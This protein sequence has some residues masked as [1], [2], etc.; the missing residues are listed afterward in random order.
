MFNRDAA[1]SMQFS[2]PD[3]PEQ[4]QCITHALNIG[5]QF[6]ILTKTAIFRMLTAE[7]VDPERK[8]P[9]TRHSYEKLYSIGTQT[10]MIART[11][12]QFEEILGLAIQE[13]EQKEKLLLQ[14][15]ECTKILLACEKSL[16]HIYSNTMD[17]M[18]KCDQV[19]ETH[20][21][22]A[23]IPALPKIPD[24][25]THVSEFLLNGKLLLINSFNF[26]HD[27]F[28]MPFNGKN[29][30]HFDKHQQ[31]IEKQFGKVHPIH[32]MIS[33]DINWI[34]LISE[35]SNAIR[36]PEKGQTIEVENITLKPGNQFSIPAWRYDL[37]KKGLGRQDDFTDLLHN[38]GIFEHNMVT[39]FEELLIL[40]IQEKIKD[41][42]IFSL[43]K[44]KAE[45]V[46]QDC[47][48]LYEINLK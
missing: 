34:R 9:D 7:T 23:N 15:W 29:A 36:H 38:F 37:T 44:K 17:L 2:D 13:R 22:K 4:E 25:D 48:V 46:Q 24:L 5:G 39:F 11:I 12:I 28:G 21:N 16:Y 14:V 20:K 18:P 42:P 1:I 40:C 8:H 19:I 10:P 47:P 45:H 35:C 43:Y 33:D 41:H 3:N 6:L 27:F 32:Q 31:W 30:A 26:L